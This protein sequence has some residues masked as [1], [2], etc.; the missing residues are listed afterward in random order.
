MF[1]NTDITP[2]PPNDSIGIIWSSL[3]EYICKLSPHNDAIFATCDI[4]P[5]AS[6]I[7]TM[8]SIFDS[9]KHVSGFILTPVLLGT[10]YSIIGN[11][12]LFA[13]TV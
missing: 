7:A 1:D 8:L 11:D 2:I 13:I 5:L 6:F 9:S 10:L 12:V 4:L 3:P